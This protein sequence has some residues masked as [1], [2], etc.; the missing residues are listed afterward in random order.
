MYAVRAFFYA[1][2]FGCSSLPT[3]FLVLNAICICVSENSMIVSAHP[4]TPLPVLVAFAP[5]MLPC[6]FAAYTPLF[7]TR[8]S[9]V[10]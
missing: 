4:I 7:H 1:V 6:R 2:V 5:S 3:I 8:Y 10:S 9:S